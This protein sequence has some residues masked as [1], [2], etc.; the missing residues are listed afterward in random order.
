MPLGRCQ[1]E[2]ER[3]L[4]V[5]PREEHLV[6]NILENFLRLH[7][8]HQQQGERLLG[9]ARERVGKAMIFATS[10]P[11]NFCKILLLLCDVAKR[12]DSKYCK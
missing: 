3:H 2:V 9:G 5:V 8:A 12:K 7:I 1:G 10:L 11:F 6:H 4:R